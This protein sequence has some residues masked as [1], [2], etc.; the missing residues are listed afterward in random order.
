[1][2]KATVRKRKWYEFLMGQGE[3][4]LEQGFYLEAVFDAYMVIDDRMKAICRLEGIPVKGKRPMLGAHLQ[5]VEAYLGRHPKGVLAGCLNDAGLVK[6]LRSWTGERNIWMHDGGN[7]KLT[8]EEY[9]TQVKELA[10]EGC[11]LMRALCNGVMRLRKQR[12]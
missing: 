4:A 6:D 2:K 1:M 3:R 7:R 10:Q 8:P 9:E 12:T 11:R 5:A